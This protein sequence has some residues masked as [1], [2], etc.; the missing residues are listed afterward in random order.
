LKRPSNWRE[1][2]SHRL[3]PGVSPTA[4]AHRPRK[5]FGQHFLVDPGI[6]RRLVSVIDPRPGQEMVEIGPGEGVMTLPLIEALG[7]LDVVELDRDLAAG[8]AEKLGN[9]AGLVIHSA[10]ALE[11]DYAALA[12]QPGSLRVVGNLPYNISTPLLFHLFEHNQ[13]IRDMHFMLQKEVV[14]RLVAGPGS[15]TYGRLSVMAGFHCR[16]EM[17]FEVPPGAF[18][19]P[20]KVDSAVIRLVP[21]E[22]TAEERALLPALGSLVGAAFSKRRKTLR[23]GLS[24]L[25]G[26]AEITLAGLEGT[27]RPETLGLDTWLRLARLYHARGN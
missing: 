18:R 17:L 23:N 16:M 8:L 19:P 26:P 5:R 9:P 21:L 22:R 25:L 11:Y 1:P 7:R 10:D 15:R 2:C 24:G 27:E 4:M 20:P 12:S 3:P 14:D 13:A 6:I